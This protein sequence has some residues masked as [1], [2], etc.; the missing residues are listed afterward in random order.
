MFL[1]LPPNSQ[2]WI[3]DS[4]GWIPLF[5]FAKEYI[6]TKVTRH[7]IDEYELFTH[8]VH[9]SKCVV[10]FFSVTLLQAN[11]IVTRHVSDLK[12]ELGI[13]KRQPNLCVGLVACTWA[14]AILVVVSAV[15]GLV[16]KI[17]PFLRV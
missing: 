7:T 11:I 8:D 13:N 9:T 10:T 2:L 4:H 6:R 5:S 15:V 3:N 16:G 14:V 1:P 17:K 12:C